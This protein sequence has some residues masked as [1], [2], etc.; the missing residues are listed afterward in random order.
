MPAE[1][2][3]IVASSESDWSR[4]ERFMLTPTHAIETNLH[5]RAMSGPSCDLA[6]S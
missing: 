1:E 3:G 4:N 5:Y 2:S 6:G